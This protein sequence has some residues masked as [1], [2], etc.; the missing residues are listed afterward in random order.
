MNIVSRGSLMGA[1][2]GAVSG[3]MVGAGPDIIHH[4]WPNVRVHGETYYI[5]PVGVMTAGIPASIVCVFPGLA[6]GAIV[7][8]GLRSVQRHRIRKGL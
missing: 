6:I 1:F 5:W 8:V 7:G 4:V 3:F 2:M